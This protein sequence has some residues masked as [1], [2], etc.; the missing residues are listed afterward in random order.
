TLGLYAIQVVIEDLNDN[1]E[2]KS[3]VAMD[4][5]INLQEFNNNQPP[6][7][8]VPPTPEN[9]RTITAVVGQTLSF[10]VVASD[11]D[12]GDIITIGHVGL[13]LGA[14]FETS[15]NADS[16]SATFTWVPDMD[17]LGDHLVTFTANDNKGSAAL[18][19]GLRIEV[20]K[21][22]ISDVRVIDR[23]STVDID[24]DVSSFSQ[25]PFRVEAFDGYSEIEWRFKTLDVDQIENLSVDLALSGLSA[26]ET[27]LVTH[28]VSLKYLDVN[29]NPVEQNLGE[30]SVEVSTSVFELLVDTDKAAYTANQD[31]LITTQL[32]NL[33]HFRNTSEVVVNILDQ[34]GVLVQRLGRYEQQT[35]AANSTVNLT[36]INFNTQATSVGDYQVQAQLFDVNGSLQLSAS[37]GFKI[38]TASGGAINLSSAIHT[39][40]PQYQ[41]WDQVALNGRVTNIALNSQMTGG[42][43]VVE[44]RNS[45][46]EKL[47]DETRGIGN[48][49]PG[50]INDFSFSLTLKDQ[51]TGA[52]SVKWLIFS[53]SGDLISNSETNFTVNRKNTQVYSGTVSVDNSLVYP[54]EL[55]S[56]AYKVQNRSATAN[57]NLTVRYQLLDMAT[58][59]VISQQ[60]SNASIIGNGSVNHTVNIGAEPLEYGSYAC[61]LSAQLNNQWVNLGAAGFDVIRRPVEMSASMTKGNKGRLLLLTDA[62]RECSALEDI[63]VQFDWGSEFDA[64]ANLK[65]HVYD[66]NEDLIDSEEVFDWSSDTNYNH[67][68]DSADA[69]INVESI[70]K[71][72][73]SLKAPRHKLGSKYR[74]ELEVTKG[75]FFSEK[76]SWHVNTGCD[77][78]LTIGEVIEDIHLL[79]FT[80]FH[81]DFEHHDNVKGLDPY[82]PKDA[83]GVAEQNTFLKQVLEA[84]GWTYTLVHTNKDFVH[85]MRTG[86]YSAYVVLSERIHLPLLAQEEIRERVFSGTGLLLAG[87][88]DRRN[89]FLE[90]ALGIAVRGKLPSINGL[91][92][93]DGVQFSEIPFQDHVQKIRTRSAEVELEYVVPAKKGHHK[94]HDYSGRSGDYRGHH[95]KQNK[96]AAQTYYEYGLGKSIFMGFDALAMASAQ[97]SNGAITQLLADSIARL[98]V[99]AAQATATKEWPL[100]VQISNESI[101]VMA[102]ATLNLPDGAEL[103]E[104]KYFK[105][106][107]DTWQVEFNIDKGQSV[108]HTVFVRLPQ[109]A[110]EYTVG[111]NIDAQ[112]VNGS[113]A[114]I[115]ASI[116]I[117]SV[118]LKTFEELMVTAQ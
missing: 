65:V 56:C 10:Q 61:V 110:G 91:Q 83:P 34:S 113:Q 67:F 97:G 7:F 13:P 112:G 15:P 114:D 48:M 64:Y 22:G 88:H 102:T 11:P 66:A 47:L 58:S 17:D 9:N 18:P 31:V 35:L 111:L 79:D 80:L 25:I 23:V 70:G 24:I 78:S 19:H 57:D 93:L 75:W 115:N 4:F 96:K 84:N 8:D 90:S 85:E 40:K 52:Y 117:S 16:E 116:N 71:V 87:S 46:G 12:A 51:L 49:V 63:H 45:N 86:D 60:T 21:P 82:G 62:E 37:H 2:V 41:A 100:T 32:N 29:S 108:E 39:D 103:I 101:P 50:A 3:S 69:T 106:Q 14:K 68:S 99:S 92:D 55:N 26:G 107:G 77:R 95:D 54:D 27:R 1:G 105:K 59:S 73:V 28:Q 81:E 109:E 5:I 89:G 118:E 76:K 72:N 104:D 74:I 42:T 44:V 33:S 38:V 20:I 98:A 94:K 30:Q 53:Y 43:A 36:D 6:V